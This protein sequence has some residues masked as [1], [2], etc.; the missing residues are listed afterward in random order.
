V[1]I[2]DLE[3]RR[4]FLWLS[5]GLNGGRCD[6]EAG[7]VVGSWCALPLA[8][9]T[10]YRTPPNESKAPPPPPELLF[11]RCGGGTARRDDCDCQ[12]WLFRLWRP[13]S[14]SL[15]LLL[16]PSLPLLLALSLVA[17]SSSSSSSSS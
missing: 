5:R 12:C 17:P 4:P 8:S 16:S 9:R 14:T 6:D 13:A 10:V 15:E 11:R 2:D 7:P 1:P 3:E